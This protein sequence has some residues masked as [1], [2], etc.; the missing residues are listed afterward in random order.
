MDRRDGVRGM[1]DIL[2]TKLNSTEMDCGAFPFHLI[3]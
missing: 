1:D 2:L 3:T